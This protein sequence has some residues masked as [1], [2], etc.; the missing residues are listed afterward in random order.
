MKKSKE[1]EEIFAERMQASKLKINGQVILGRANYQLK[2]EDSM[3]TLDKDVERLSRLG[4]TRIDALDDMERRLKRMRHQLK[5]TSVPTVNDRISADLYLNNKANIEN[6]FSVCPRCNRKILTNLLQVHDLACA[7]LQSD[8]TKFLGLR[9]VPNVGEEIQ[10]LIDEHAVFVPQPPRRVRV[11][12]KGT[13]YIVWEWDKPVYEGGWPVTDYE[14]SYAANIAD[15]NTK[16]K[17]YDRYREVCPSLST[18]NWCFSEP[19]THNGYTMVGLRAGTEYTD[20]KIRCRNKH[21][22]SE[23]VDMVSPEEDKYDPFAGLSNIKTDKVARKR[24]KT[25]GVTTNPAEPATPPLYF[26]CSLITTSCV[27]LQVPSP[28]RF[29]SIYSPSLCHHKS[30]HVFVPCNSG[31]HPSTTAGCQLS[32]TPYITQSWSTALRPQIVTAWK[33]DPTRSYPLILTHP[34]HTNTPSFYILC[35]N[36]TCSQLTSLLIYIL[37]HKTFTHNTPYHSNTPFH[38]TPSHMYIGTPGQGAY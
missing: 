35:H 3:R 22:W 27:H 16:T 5:V 11:K 36:N 4:R 9:P 19:I 29:I 14:I 1:D 31:T 30:M 17:K 26:L 23:W 24:V 32:S 18:S 10:S 7:R 37:S 15:F 2:I 25:V 38:N 13:S 21:G 8:D 34:P 20:L 28:P 6:K 33:S 12:Q